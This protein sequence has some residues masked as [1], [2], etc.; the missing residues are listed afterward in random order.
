M[1]TFL[2]TDVFPR[3]QAETDIKNLTH[4]ADFIGISRPAVSKFKKK[5]T[6]PTDW[7]VAIELKYGLCTRWILTGHG[8]MR[9]ND[10][11]PE[12]TRPKPQI[13][14]AGFLAELDAWAREI[15]K[16]G[17]IN[18]LEEQLETC[19]PTW[20]MWRKRKKSGGVAPLHPDQVGK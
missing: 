4:L 18:W 6:F 10:G 5:N 15:S 14:V 16:D 7:A 20:Q 8:P 17:G 3:I 9:H 13:T 1:T 2:F 12:A 11:N 19:L